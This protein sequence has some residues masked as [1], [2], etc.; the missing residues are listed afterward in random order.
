[1]SSN[2]LAKPETN[3]KSNK[4]NKNFL[5]AGSVQ[6][7]IE[8]NIENLDEILHNNN[9]QMDY[10]AMQIVSNDKTVRCDTVQD[11]KELNSQSLATQAKKGKQ[12]VSM[13]PA[14]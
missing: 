4:Q 2:E 12:L 7:N 3:T 13:M 14:N 11:L 6:E 9:L 8:N 5:K 1:M 10:L